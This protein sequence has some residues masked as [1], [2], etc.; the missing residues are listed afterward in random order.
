MSNEQAREFYEVSKNDEVLQEKLKDS[1]NLV[2]VME[3]AS[4]K[5]YKFTESELQAVMQEAVA[6]D[7]LSEEDLYAIAGGGELHIHQGTT[8]IDVVY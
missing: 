2:S 7:E 3:I 8:H 6:E 4:E 5:G 1:K